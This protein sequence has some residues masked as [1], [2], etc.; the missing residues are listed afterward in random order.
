[1]EFDYYQVGSSLNVIN[2]PWGKLGNQYMLRQLFRCSSCS[3]CAGKN[4]AVCILSPCS[5]TVDHYLTEEHNV[6][7]NKW[8]EPFTKIAQAFELPV[9]GG[10]G[11]GYIVGGPYEGKKMP[12]GSLVAFPDGSFL[13]GVFNEFSSSS[14]Y[15]E[16]KLLKTSKYKGVQW[17]KRLRQ[18]NYE[19]NIIL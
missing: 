3:Q 8:K 17:G 5:W 10:T 2:S 4:G 7:Q 14:L 19:K 15:V 1:M 6:Y 12:G 9:V 18:I 16:L 11:V 13:E